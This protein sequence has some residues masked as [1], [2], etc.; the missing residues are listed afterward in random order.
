[1]KGPLILGSYKFLIGH[2]S[3]TKQKNEL[4]EVLGHRQVIP[5]RAPLTSPPKMRFPAT[6]VLVSQVNNKLI[7]PTYITF[8]D[9]ID[10]LTAE[11]IK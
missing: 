8:L 10:V 1:M 5:K 2:Y 3:L 6:C 9:L 11:S 7:H 4:L